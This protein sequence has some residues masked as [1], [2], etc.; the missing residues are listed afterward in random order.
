MS[1]KGAIR[2]ATK[3]AMRA[4]KSVRELIA[5]SARADEEAY[6]AETDESTP[7]DAQLP[8]I[9]AIFSSYEEKEID[10]ETIRPMDERCTIETRH[11]GTIDPVENDFI[12]RTGAKAGQWEIMN[13]KKPT[14]SAIVILQVRRP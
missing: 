5:Y 4:Q 9:P 13:V 12:T 7:D 3:M 6:D 2:N 11:L 1:L 8:S 10:G 14:G